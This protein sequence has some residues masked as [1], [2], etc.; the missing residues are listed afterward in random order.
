FSFFILQVEY[1]IDISYDADQ[2]FKR[3]KYTTYNFTL[4]AYWSPYLVTV[5]ESD[6]DGP[7][8]TGLF[9]LYLDEPDPKWASQIEQFD[10]LIFNSAHWFT[11]C[12]VYYEKN[13]IIGCRY[14]GLPNV[15]EVP[16][17]YAYQK[18]LKTTL[19]A[20]NSLDKFKGVTFLRTIAPSHF[21]GGE[22]NKGGNC[23]RKSPF[24]SNETTLDSI[25]S[26]FYKTQVEEFKVAAEEGKKKGKRFRLLDMTQAMW[27]RPDGHPSKYGH[28]PNANVV[29]YNDCVHWCLPGPIDTWSDFLL[30]MLKLEG[31]RALE[32][33]LQ[34][35]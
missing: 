24:R 1:P 23:V 10:Y 16:I 27:L 22:W 14:C 2:N 18:A 19:K 7:S 8:H 13:Q 32:E 6:P 4:A 26:E 28:W 12:S 15:T 25:S 21:E 17:N 29:L 11:R 9:N 5:K 33:K 30:H 3:W 20:I 31:R 35:K 34:L